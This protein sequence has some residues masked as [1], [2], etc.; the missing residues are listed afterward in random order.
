MEAP[1]EIGKLILDVLKRAG[2]GASDVQGSLL[3]KAV[4]LRNKARYDDAT[5][6]LRSLVQG[7]DDNTEARY[8]LAVCELK[9]S[10]RKITRGPNNEPCIVTFAE[11]IKHRDFPLLDRLTTDKIVEPD[12]LF[13]LGFSFSERKGAEQSFGGDVLVHLSE[14]DDAAVSNRATNKLRTMGWLE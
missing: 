1:P 3:D 11:L 10:K 9:Q 14:S 4:I 7:D 2:G 8:H 13:Y 12:D 6:M 5:A